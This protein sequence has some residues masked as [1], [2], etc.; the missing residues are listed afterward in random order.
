MAPVFQ[1]FG[2]RAW[3]A[4]DDYG[5]VLEVRRRGPGDVQAI[6]EIPDL[7]VEARG[8]GRVSLTQLFL[9]LEY[10]DSCPGRVVLVAKLWDGGVRGEGRVRARD[11]TGS[12]SGAIS[13][14]RRPFAA[15]GPPPTR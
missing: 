13:L 15:M 4:G 5:L 9:D 3:F 12:E 2:G 10:G 8:G 7:D 6:L 11:C 1:V 14:L